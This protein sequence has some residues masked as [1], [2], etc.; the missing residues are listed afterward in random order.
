MGSVVLTRSII[1]PHC[2]YSISKSSSKYLGIC[3]FGDNTLPG[4]FLEVPLL[5]HF[6]G[7]F[8]WSGIMICLDQWHV[9]LASEPQPSLGHR[10]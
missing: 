3:S 2:I 5:L 4:T 7:L 10:D 6:S 8:G 9:T 1:W